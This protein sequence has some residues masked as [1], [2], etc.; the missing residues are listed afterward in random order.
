MQ[1]TSVTTCKNTHIKHTGIGMYCVCITWGN[2]R[3]IEILV[4]LF[5]AFSWGWWI[6]PII[7]QGQNIPKYGIILGHDT[8]CSML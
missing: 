5:F 1:P 7:N 4:C 6:R 3:L 8:F 2:F